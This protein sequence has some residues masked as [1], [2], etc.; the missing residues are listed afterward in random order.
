MTEERPRPG[1][2]RMGW[3]AASLV[4]GLQLG[5]GGTLSILL[6]GK[7][8]QTRGPKCTLHTHRLVSLVP[9]IQELARLA[10]TP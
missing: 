8:G 7:R 1:Q 3:W 5:V 2:G 10:V 9:H 6:Q 4:G